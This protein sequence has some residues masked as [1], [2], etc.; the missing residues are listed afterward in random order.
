MNLR[1]KLIQLLFAIGAMS[2]TQASMAAIIEST[3]EAKVYQI[4]AKISV[5]GQEIS[6]PQMITLEG[7]QALIQVG[8][9]GTESYYELS[10]LANG[11]FD[12]KLNKE[13]I[14]L[15][16]DVKMN[17]KGKAAEAKPSLRVSSGEKAQVK[18]NDFAVMD[19]EV[20]EIE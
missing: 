3:E 8:Q 11:A 9:K 7:E 13:F 2:L 20:T 17:H 10:V 4:L 14:D 18:I 6:Q 16:L 15:N 1:N 5:D 12:E 19:V